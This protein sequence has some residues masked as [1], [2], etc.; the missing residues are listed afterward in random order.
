LLL[1]W[2]L[3]VVV[4]FLKRVCHLGSRVT[5]PRNKRRPPAASAEDIG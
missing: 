2:G 4:Q 5:L 1:K 3:S